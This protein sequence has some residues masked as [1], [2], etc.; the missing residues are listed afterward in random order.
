M[1]R[2][3]PKVWVDIEKPF[4]W[5]VPIWLAG[6]GKV[7]S[8]GIA[9]NHMTRDEMFSPNPRPGTA[10]A[11]KRSADRRSEAKGKSGA[12]EPQATRIK[13][14][15]TD[16][17]WGKPRDY[18]RLPSPHGNGYWSQ[19][20]YYHALNTGIR[21]PPSAGSASG[22][23]PNPL[24]YNRVWVHLGPGNF[25]LRRLV[26]RPGRG[27]L[28]SSPTA[29]FSAS[30]PTTNSPATYSRARKIITID[31]A[32][33]PRQPRPHPRPRSHRQRRSRPIPPA[34]KKIAPLEFTESGWFLL[35]AIADVDETFRFASTAPWYVEIGD[36]PNRISAASTRFFLDWTRERRE[37]AAANLTDPTQRNEV[38]QHHDAAETFWQERLSSANAR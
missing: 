29:P 17:A 13:D 34:S 33:P 6:A 1:A 4:W 23:L 10:P 18:D 3:N 28:P 30:A 12:W 16:E 25:L 14:A 11:A 36:T 8:I 22:V 20:I 35:R 37:R 19:E 38:L 31:L 2:K 32:H 24:G 21:L 9:N 5:D 15:W 7:N 27:P 26:G